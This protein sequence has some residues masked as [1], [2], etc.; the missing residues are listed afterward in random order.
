MMVI[1]LTKCVSIS[2]PTDSF[3]FQAWANRICMVAIPR[4]IQRNRPSANDFVHSEKYNK[5][6]MSN[7]GGILN[8]NPEIKEFS[9]R[10]NK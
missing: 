8:G 3:D 7:K 6:R 2:F 5:V 10:G 1:V 4:V 9:L